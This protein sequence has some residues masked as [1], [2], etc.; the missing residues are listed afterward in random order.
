M[1]TVS[2]E[3]RSR[4]MQKIKSKNTKP[5]IYLRKLLHNSGFRY[6]LHSK[7]IPGKPDVYLAKYNTAIYIHGCFWHQHS[8]CRYS[9]IPK[10]NQDYWIPK[11]ERNISRDNLVKESLKKSG[12]KCLIIWEC[13]I[14]QMTKN[15][16]IKTKILE[17][18][19]A[20]IKDAA[21][22]YLEI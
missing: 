9:N 8:N 22:L 11:L 17:Q 2:K 21:S 13:T 18:I 14:K 1:D 10:T 5:E 7:K 15:E 20:F 19:V 3:V 16:E 4:N 6:R 12:I